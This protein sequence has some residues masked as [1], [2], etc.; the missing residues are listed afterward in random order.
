MD[1]PDDLP[2]L[3]RHSPTT[4]LVIARRSFLGTAKVAPTAPEDFS[5]IRKF[6]SAFVD[7]CGIKRWEAD[8]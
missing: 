7:C 5:P 8:E 6:K 2:W 4:G 3:E 1:Q